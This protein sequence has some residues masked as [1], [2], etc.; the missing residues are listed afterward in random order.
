MAAT[1]R[2]PGGGRRGLGF[3]SIWVGYSVLAR[4]PVEALTTLAAVA[5]RTSRAKQGAAVLLPASRQPVVLASEVPNLDPL[6]QGRIILGV[7][8]IRSAWACLPCNQA[9]CRY[10]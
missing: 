8:W 1:L 3:D 2:I 10:G 6:S 4:P 5:S 9:V 7:G